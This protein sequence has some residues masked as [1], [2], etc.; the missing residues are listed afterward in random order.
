[1]FG[2]RASR[3][4]ILAV[5]ALA[6]TGHGHAAAPAAIEVIPDAATAEL[7]GVRMYP[8]GMFRFP[9]NALPTCYVLNNFADPRDGGTRTHEGV[10]IAARLGQEIYAVTDGI[11]EVRAVDYGTGSTAVTK[12][13]NYVRVYLQDGSGMYTMYGHLSA[14]GPGIAAVAGTRVPVKMGQVIGYVGDTGNPGPGNYHLHFEYHPTGGAAVD[15]VPHLVIPGTCS[16][17]KKS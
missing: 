10:D 5:V 9:M 4:A 16:V 6:F 2:N 11:V 3:A 7:P 12:S 1:M 8:P 14:F 13:G 15:P 17:Y